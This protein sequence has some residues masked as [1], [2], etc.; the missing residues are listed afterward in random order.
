MLKNLFYLCFTILLFTACGDD[1]MDPC[2]DVDCGA[3]GVCVD[4]TCDCNEG[5]YGDLCESLLQDRFLGTWSGVDCDGDPYSITVSAG[6]TILDLVILNNG[7]EFMA[8]I[9][10][11]TVFVMPTQTV[12]EPFF[13]SEVIVVGNGTLLEDDL[14]SFAATV[15]SIFGGGSCTSEL[16]LQ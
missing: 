12:I 8:T 10:S 5:Y 9:E 1:P 6:E 13:Q 4:G 3:N 16:T 2:A 7:L 11:P 15:T 14:L